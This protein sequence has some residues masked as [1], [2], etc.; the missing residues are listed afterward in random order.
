MNAS[1]FLA[2]TVLASSLAM[3]ALAGATTLDYTVLGDITGMSSFSTNGLTATA[4][5]GGTLDI[6]SSGLGVVG[7]VHPFTIDTSESVL[8]SFDSGGATGVGFGSATAFRNPSVP[9]TTPILVEA[10]GVGGASLG[11]WGFPVFGTV[12]MGTPIDVS[13]LFGNVPLTAFRI[14]GSGVEAGIG[15]WQ[16]KYTNAPPQAPAVP[17]PTTLVLCASGLVLVGWR[18]SRATRAPRQDEDAGLSRQDDAG[19]N[20]RA[21]PLMQ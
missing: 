4:G 18:K 15:V 11:V 19:L 3:P 7:G 17:E 2:T 10:F 5:G 6:N 21:M 8:F 12:G 9:A 16:V 13:G 1:R 20:V 14:A